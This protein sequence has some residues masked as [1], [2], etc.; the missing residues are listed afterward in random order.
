MKRR[1]VGRIAW[2]GMLAL[3]LASSGVY[4]QVIINEVAWAGTSA[5]SNDEWVE[6]CN[7]SDRAVDVAGWTLKI[8]GSVI[9]LGEVA[10]ATLE[11]R[12]TLIEAGGFLLLERTDDTTVSDVQADLIYKGLLSNGGEDLFLSNAEG[13]IVDQAL[14][15]EAGWPAGL[16]TDEA[17]PYATM[18]RLDPSGSGV[19]WATNA[20][21]ASRN[22]L[23][24]EGNPLNG[25]PR[26]V[27]GAV[28]FMA[29]AP[30]VDLM[31]PTQGDVGGTALIEWLAID[32]DGEDTAL[33]VRITLVHEDSLEV[34]TL[35]ENLT[36]AGSYPWDTTA[37][38]DGGYHFEIYVEDPDGY[39]GTATSSGLVI[40]NES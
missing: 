31:G 2:A 12:G 34:E 16:G 38:E 9:H 26:A 33:R 35:A 20:P 21:M 11:V 25:T 39:V 30:R 22:G 27:N 32:P 29:S 3:A 17:L 13:E 15:A 4:G 19:G 36:N 40:Q 1:R 18:E 8:D 24:A 23:D 7:V 6:L 10:D 28:L 37:H 14:F 5:S